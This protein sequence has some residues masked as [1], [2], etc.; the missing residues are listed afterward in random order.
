[1]GDQIELITMLIYLKFEL[2]LLGDA[3]FKFDKIIL[4]YRYETLTIISSIMYANV[5]V[6]THFNVLDVN[7]PFPSRVSN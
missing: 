6:A 2:F 1:M 7:T 4:L 5:T 3:F